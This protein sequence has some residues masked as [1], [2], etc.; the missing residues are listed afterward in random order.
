MKK[1]VVVL[2]ASVKPSR[3]SHMA[4]ESLRDK[5]YNV[6]P[7]HPIHKEILGLK[8]FKHISDI[9][10]KVDTL[11]LYVSEYVSNKII[12]EIVE[13]KPGRVIFNP[14]TE[15]PVLVKALKNAGIQVIHGCT[16]VMLNTGM[17]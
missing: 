12:D 14:G 8:V 15:N 3:Y 16:L 4:V 5:G 10:F 2:G 1:T 7:V 9:D 11:T 6:V 17:F 13:S